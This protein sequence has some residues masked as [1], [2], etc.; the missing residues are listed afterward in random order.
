MADNDGTSV[1]SC[2]SMADNDGA[3]VSS[4]ESTDVSWTPSISSEEDSDEENESVWKETP[5]QASKI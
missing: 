3:S 1:L 4:C 2:E 5:L